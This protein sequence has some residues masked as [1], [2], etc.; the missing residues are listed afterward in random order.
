MSGLRTQERWRKE[1]VSREVAPTHSFSLRTGPL[2]RARDKHDNSPAGNQSRRRAMPRLGGRRASAMA[3]RW[4]ACCRLGSRPRPSAGAA[5]RERP[6]LCP[7][8]SVLGAPPHSHSSPLQPHS[9]SAQSGRASG[10]SRAASARAA[11]AAGAAPN[12]QPFGI[13][14]TPRWLAPLSVSDG[15]PEVELSQGSFDKSQLLQGTSPTWQKLTISQALEW[16]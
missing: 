15:P 14:T 2:N 7:S 9:H 8:L 5:A 1:G 12:R 10:P 4:R 11:G 16:F 6:S 3:R 13:G